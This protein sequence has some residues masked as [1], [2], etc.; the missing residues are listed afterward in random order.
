[1]C[2]SVC[3][4]KPKEFCRAARHDP[5]RNGSHFQPDLGMVRMRVAAL[6]VFKYPA[7]TSYECCIYTYCCCSRTTVRVHCSPSRSHTRPPP[8]EYIHQQ[9]HSARTRETMSLAN[10]NHK[11]RLV[12]HLVSIGRH[13]PTSSLTL[14]AYSSTVVHFFPSCLPSCLF[15]LSPL[16]AALDFAKSKS[17]IQSSITMNGVRDVRVSHF[18]SKPFHTQ[19]TAAREMI[20][21]TLDPGKVFVPLLIISRD[22]AGDKAVY[23]MV[24]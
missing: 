16:S 4:P 3:A 2:V 6:S 9:N 10:I 14:H 24:R 5:N 13:T 18:P 17:K 7:R 12:F 1:M 11:L 21:I 22:S 19:N 8:R 15:F 20:C 23:F